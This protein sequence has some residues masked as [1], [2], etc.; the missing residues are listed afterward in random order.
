MKCPLPG[1]LFILFCLPLP[2]QA[3]EPLQVTTKPLEAVLIHPREEA[4]AESRALLDGLI[5]AQVGATVVELPVQV[6][7]TVKSG[8]LVVRLDPWAYRLAERRAAAELDGLRARL[9]TARKRAE[10]A[11]QLHAQKQASEER[12]EQSESEVKELAAQARAVEVSMEDARTRVEKC[13]VKAP[14]DGVVVQR[15]ARVG[16]DAAPGTPLAQLVDHRH[17]ELS[18]TIASGR[19]DSLTRAPS[20]HFSHEGRD[21]PVKL[22]VVVPVVDPAS[23]AREARLLFTG[24][25][26]VPGAAGRLVWSDARPHL[27]PWLLVR[28]DA[29]LGFFL[30]QGDKAAFQPL[31]QALEGHPALLDPLP[32]G[33]VVISGRESLT[34][35]AAIQPIPAPP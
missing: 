23:R 33:T 13:L 31:P 18:A 26:P 8:D 11:R 34:H 9:E 27:P 29:T 25:R 7:D 21:Y 20:W 19:I 28:R 3:D 14:F 16:M 2:S 35:G 17:V 24:D 15:Q 32:E 1:W 4:P 12:V 30:A 5:T 10:R 6:G 22:R